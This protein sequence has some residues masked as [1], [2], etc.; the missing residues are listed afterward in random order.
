M[1][2]T[3]TAGGRIVWGNP[4]NGKP[5]IDDNTKQPKLNKNQQP[6][7]EWAFGL[8]VPKAEFTPTM[9]ALQQAAAELFAA[10]VPTNFSWK[11]KDGDGVDQ[12]GLPF[13]TREGYAGCWIITI[14]TTAF[15]P[16]VVRLNNGA[17]V[18]WSEVKTGDYVRASLTLKA[19]Q[20]QTP[21]IYVNPGMIEFL[22]YGEAIISGPDAQTVFGGVAAVLPPGASA[23]PLAPAGPMPGQP[24]MQPA[25]A[26]VAGPM[27]GQPAPVFTPPAAAPMPQPVATTPAPAMAPPGTPAPLPTAYPS[28]PAPAPAHDFVQNAGQ[29]VAAPVYAVPVAA[30]VYAAPVAA[31]VAAVPGQVAPG[32]PGYPVQ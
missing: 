5:V 8:A 30:P 13:N 2:E 21:G 4:T 9:T 16:R 32:T 26:P 18:D 6:M 20:S 12:N 11:L 24:V 3:V 7:T 10:G 28:N 17:Y 31:P 1:I 29:P 25:M 19:H 22:G 23:A 14:S 27:P 15:A